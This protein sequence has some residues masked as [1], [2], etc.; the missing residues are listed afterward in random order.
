MTGKRRAGPRKNG[1]PPKKRKRKIK[2]ILLKA[3]D[4]PQE[5]EQTVPKL[6]MLGQT[7]LLVE[8]H[9]GVLQY[10]HTLI[11]LLTHEGVLNIKGE[12]LQLME[13]AKFRAYVQGNI[14]GLEYTT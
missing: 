12:A 2:R 14:A 3:F 7:D 6:T 1:A 10:E 13:L 8:N 11:R 9:A 4:L 5:T